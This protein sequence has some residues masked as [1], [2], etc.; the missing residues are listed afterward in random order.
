MATKSL[1]VKAKAKRATAPRKASRQATG[2]VKHVKRKLSQREL[3][4]RILYRCA[5]GKDQLDKKKAPGVRIVP[6]PLGSTGL[7]RFPQQ[8]TRQEGDKTVRRGAAEWHIPE[9]A[10]P[11][12]RMLYLHGGTY[13]VWAPQDAPYRSL[14]S[15]L[16]KACGLCV[17]AIDYRMAP[18][19]KFPAAF[20]D[21][22]VALEWITQH[23]PDSPTAVS[24]AKDVFVCGDS[25]GG[26][27]AVAA[28]VA[29]SAAVRSVLR[30]C[31][32]LSAWMDLTASTPSY[33][34]RGWDAVKCFGDSVNAGQTREEGQEEAT[35]Y[36]GRDGIQKHGRDWRCSPYFAPA[37]K[38]CKMPA[39]LFSVGDYELILDESIL[40]CKRMKKAGHRDAAVS[41]WPRM[42]HVF[43]QYAEGGGEGVPLTKAIKAVQEVGRWVKARKS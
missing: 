8:W 15:R 19:H 35:G 17:L 38:L 31:I 16:A 25:A 29:P 14:C 21:T 10:D 30:G 4:T 33:D 13:V 43:H 36:L 22:Q 5:K 9:G 11:A 42:W 34:T 3:E 39:T 20:E 18:E 6:V 24:P 7:R 28:C 12:R 27:L 40:L 23:G 41:V 26:G 1:A 2:K 32:G 37:S